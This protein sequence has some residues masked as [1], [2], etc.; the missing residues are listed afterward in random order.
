[1][2]HLLCLITMLPGLAV[3][4]LAMLQLVLM[5]LLVITKLPA[6]PCDE[7]EE[8]VCPGGRI[9]VKIRESLNLKIE[10]TSSVNII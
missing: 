10:K 8:N 5:M 3:M 2:L 6:R 9:A 4:L 7:F 1:M